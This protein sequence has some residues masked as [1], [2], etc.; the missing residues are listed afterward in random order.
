MLL[1]LFVVS[2]CSPIVQSSL[3]PRG[4]ACPLHAHA[5]MAPLQ[6]APAAAAAVPAAAPFD[7][8]S[9]L[10]G[11]E[12]SS[13]PALDMP[14]AP[15]A[16]DALLPSLLPEQIECAVPKKRTSISRQRHR[17]AGARLQNRRRVYQNYRVCFVC[18]TAVLQHHLC[19]TNRKKNKENGESGER[20]GGL[21]LRQPPRLCVV[22]HP[23]TIALLHCC[24]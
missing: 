17:R 6:A 16:S 5:L 22:A 1:S 11:V 13:A 24:L 10:R 21:R 7:L 8:L 3:H 9:F 2:F 14:C 23:L 12:C 19:Q 15:A 18:G 20:R 4:C